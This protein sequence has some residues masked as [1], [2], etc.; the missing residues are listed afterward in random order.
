MNI[1]FRNDEYRLSLLSEVNG[2]TELISDLEKDCKT[3]IINAKIELQNNNDTIKITSNISVNEDLTFDRLFIRL[4]ID[5]Y[6]KQ[7]PEW[8]DKLFPTLIR[9][10]KQGI[11]GCF[12]SP[13]GVMA[14]I[15]SS[16]TFISW[17]NEYEH[18]S[19]VGYRIYTVS[20][21]ILNKFK[22][23]KGHPEP[24]G[25]LLK[26]EYSYSVYIKTVSDEDEL[27]SFVKAYSGID[28]CRFEKYTLEEWE[29]PVALFDDKYSLNNINGRC[30]VE[31][32]NSKAARTK[33][34]FRK[35]WS[36]YLEN[37]AKYVG[38][39]QQKSGTH[40]ESWYG[41][42]TMAEYARYINDR[43]YTERL[44]KGFDAFYKFNTNRFTG[45]LKKK[46]Y[47]SRLQNISGMIS[48]LVCFFRLTDNVKYLSNANIL[49]TQLMT[50]QKGDGA[51]YSHSTHYTCVIYPAKSMLE[52]ALAEKD[53]GL[54]ERF[55]VHYKSS[56]R[57]VMN[58]AEL[59]DNIETEGD[60]T[61]EDGM[62]SC[63][64][65]QLAYFALHTDDISLRQ[66]LTDAAEYVLKKHK[67]LEQIFAPDARI[68]GCTLRFWEA[69]YD[70][71]FNSN[72][73]NSPH[74][75]TSW[76]TYATYYLY[77]LTGKSSYLKD[78]MDTMGA[79]VQCIDDNG[80]L[81]WA[82]I[83]DP[84]IRGKMM[85]PSDSKRGYDFKEVVVGEEYMPMISDWYKCNPKK[86]VFQYIKN[87]NLP[88]KKF[89]PDY[90]GS[91]DNDVNEHFK[92][93][94]ETVLNKAFI[95]IENGSVLL[96]GCRKQGNGYV[97]SGDLPTV[98]V[99]FTAEAKSL[100]FNDKA[101]NL[102][103]GINYIKLN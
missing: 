70:I 18:K 11:W 6:M 55:N 53:A 92:C 84:G 60:M 52:L 98:L 56:Q 62:I 38:K 4:G 57:A 73:L 35:P 65:L 67:C 59:L 2:K 16:D 17:K 51:F 71:N 77:L 69:R 36:Y 9:C 34:F 25:K 10:E 39:C 44:V 93:L 103:K 31:F 27:Y 45:K 19:D 15:A 66:K 76:K 80:A 58:L 100:I 64:A 102:N 32:E 24:N 3:D 89:S 99:V 20:L 74:G 30:D 48:L 86:F 13:N 95:H 33:L 83:P 75:W 28:V 88:P 91:C 37:A 78:T 40:T 49:A 61:F 12:M 96:Y 22:Q 81:N 23:P 14:G 79:C 94:A 63:E 26:G 72:M 5:C 41:Y 29:K 1:P 68:R 50:M 8:N 85:I 42:F 7:Y 54:E 21:D 97:S 43:A 47:P 46:A 87:F 82:Y 90:G 101:Y